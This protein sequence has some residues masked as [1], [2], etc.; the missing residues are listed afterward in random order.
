MIR[1][2]QRSCSTKPTIGQGRSPTNKKVVPALTLRFHESSK[3]DAR[4]GMS[5]LGIIRSTPLFDTDYQGFAPLYHYGRA[6]FTRR[7]EEWGQGYHGEPS[8]SMPKQQQASVNQT[9]HPYGAVPPCYG[10]FD[11]QSTAPKQTTASEDSSSY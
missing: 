4:Y 5:S 10:N 6:C 1:E 8:S 7:N 2:F 3:S 11:K 9:S